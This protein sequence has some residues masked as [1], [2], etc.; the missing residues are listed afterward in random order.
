[1]IG[2]GITSMCRLQRVAHS[3]TGCTDADLRCK[4]PQITEDSHSDA[5]RPKP[6]TRP[7]LPG[8]IVKPVERS[9]CATSKIPR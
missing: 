5:S 6:A 9:G 3:D 4:P 8:E 1:M 2:I 7:G